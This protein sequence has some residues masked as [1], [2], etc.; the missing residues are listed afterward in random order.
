MDDPTT[1]VCPTCEYGDRGTESWP[2][3]CCERVNKR[4]DYY[5]PKEGVKEEP[6]PADP[7][8]AAYFERHVKHCGDCPAN[9]DCITAYPDQPDF[10]GAECIG[11]IADRLKGGAGA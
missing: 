7:T 10:G 11:V 6:K 4:A 1:Y 9:A 2:C 5:T 8:A 3:R